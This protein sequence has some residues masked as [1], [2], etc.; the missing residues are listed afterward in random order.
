MAR[1]RRRETRRVA[2]GEAERDE[3]GLTFGFAFRT[4]WRDGAIWC[5]SVHPLLRNASASLRASHF[6]ARDNVAPGA[7]WVRFAHLAR[8]NIPAHSG[9]FSD[10]GEPRTVE[11]SLVN[12]VRFAQS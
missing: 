1:H 7:K 9:T 6:Q 2:R 10:T 8:W 4:P 11:I 5:I 3:P 12:W